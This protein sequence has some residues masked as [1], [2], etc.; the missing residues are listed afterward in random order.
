[1]H[2]Q[3]SVINVRRRPKRTYYIERVW[4][5]KRGFELHRTQGYG[6]FSRRPRALFGA[7]ALSCTHHSRRGLHSVVA[8]FTLSVFLS[9]FAP[10]SFFLIFITIFAI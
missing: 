10:G 3:R 8:A 7:A 5:C 4:G 9:V 2:V 6:H 1:M